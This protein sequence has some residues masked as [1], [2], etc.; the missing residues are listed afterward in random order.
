MQQ[1]QLDE[2][3]SSTPELSTIHE[4]LHWY[5]RRLTQLENKLSETSDRLSALANKMLNEEEMLNDDDSSDANPGAIIQA[6]DC[7]LTH[8][9]RCAIGFEDECSV[10]NEGSEPDEWVCGARAAAGT[11]YMRLAL[12]IGRQR[13]KGMERM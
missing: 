9:D 10:C 12:G 4:L 11:R 2:A 6:P 7:T 5:E 13:V 3:Q 1:L 8:V